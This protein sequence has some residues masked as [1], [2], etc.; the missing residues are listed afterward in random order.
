MLG[1]FCSLITNLPT[2]RKHAA[3]AMVQ[4]RLGSIFDPCLDLGDA[5]RERSHVRE[6]RWPLSYAPMVDETAMAVQH[7]T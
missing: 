4:L 2:G 6:P 3:S 7:V 5:G 1:G